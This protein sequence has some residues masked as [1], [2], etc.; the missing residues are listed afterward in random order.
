[1]IDIFKENNFG[2]DIECVG[3]TKLK[4]KE[5]ADVQTGPF[6][7]LLH[8]KDYVESGTPII[9][10]EHIRDN[11]IAHIN[12]PLVSECDVNRLEKFKLTEGD[13]VFSRVG[14]IDRHAY[15]TQ[16]EDGWLFSGRCLRI[17]VTKGVLPKYLSQFLEL[18]KVKEQILSLAVGQ[19]M[20]SLNTQIIGEIDVCHPEVSEQKKIVEILSNWDE[21]IELKG[22]L[23][24]EKKKQKLGLMQKLLTGKVRLPGFDEKWTN[25]EI[26][27]F[28]QEIS[29]IVGDRNIKP[30]A[31]GVRGIRQRD[32]IYKKELSSDY[33]KNKVIRK[34]H[35]CFGI[36]SKE[37]VYDVLIE[38]NEYCVSPAY[39]VYKINKIEPLLLKLI[40]D[41]NKQKYSSRFMIISAR[42]G[43]S[44]DFSGLM[45]EKI[46]IPKENE[47]KEL[48]RLFELLDK[49]IELLEK[50]LESLKLQK[51]GL[52][53]LLLTG[54]VRVQC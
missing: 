54:I 42:Q 19:T 13:I 36:G 4:L 8:N 24:E 25:V 35:L 21:A 44:V 18:K 50:E 9:T 27:E 31:V 15:V 51:K 40:L 39:K 3:W 22:K 10:V 1:M 48:V 34:N 26:K 45:N 53:Q 7:S 12:L 52:M 2:D 37:L 29:E 33:S 17:R 28:T 5:I 32:E 20:K 46:R 23:I 47:Q 30:I 6:G 41:I 16:R 49:S 43:K 38:N 11:K 14:S